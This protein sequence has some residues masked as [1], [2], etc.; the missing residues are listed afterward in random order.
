MTENEVRQL[1]WR[2]RD[3]RPVVRPQI[4]P[5]PRPQEPQEPSAEL[6][7]GLADLREFIREVGAGRIGAPALGRAG[8]TVPMQAR[9]G[10]LYFL[11]IFAPRYLEAPPSCTFVDG[12]GR[13]LPAAWPAYHPASPFRPPEFICTP[14]TAEFFRRHPGGYHQDLG[15]LVNAVATIY[16]ALQ[17]PTYRGRH[18]EVPD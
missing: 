7:V 13:L 16:T 11:R 18:G 15:T 5:Q 6:L 9:D 10:A 14:P 3:W 17:A 8:V 4:A 12:Q 2:F 1:R